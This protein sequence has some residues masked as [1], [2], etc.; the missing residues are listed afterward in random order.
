MWC[1]FSSY[2]L[3]YGKNPNIPSVMTANPPTLE[4]TTVSSSF[5]QHINTLDAARQAYIQAESSERIRKALRHKIRT[6][7]TVF[8]Q[9]CRVYYKRD[10]SNKWKGPGIVCGQDGKIIFIRHGSSIV[11]VSSNRIIKAGTEFQPTDSDNSKIVENNENNANNHH[12]NSES[13]DEK[14]TQNHESNEIDDQGKSNSESQV[15]KAHEM[16]AE[17]SNVDI[18]FEKEKTYPVKHDKIEYRF[19]K[20]DDYKQATILLRAGKASGK[21]KSL[22]NV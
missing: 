10:S 2:Q 16:Y 6:F 12:V 14:N 11:R 19:S 18:D 7:A 20:D 1:G 21:Y 15:H 13:D 9:G 22:Y 17:N 8:E 4:G 5:A 3:V